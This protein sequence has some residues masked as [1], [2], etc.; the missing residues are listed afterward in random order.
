[1]GFK[2]KSERARL[3]NA[4]RVTETVATEKL[5]EDCMLITQGIYLGPAPYGKGFWFGFI[6]KEEATAVVYTAVP[7]LDGKDWYVREHISQYG[8]DYRTFFERFR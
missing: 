7:T 8:G 6:D 4:R 2:L 3:N 1:L 5:G